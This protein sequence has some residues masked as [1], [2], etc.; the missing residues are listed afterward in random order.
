MW[1]KKSI[2]YS[3]IIKSDG[4]FKSCF[5]P[6]THIM[7]CQLFVVFQL[8]SHVQLFAT[9]WTV[10]C[11]ASL[12]SW[13]LYPNKE[14]KGRRVNLGHCQCIMRSVWWLKA[15]VNLPLIFLMVKA[16]RKTWSNQDSK[17][18]WKKHLSGATE[19]QSFQE[20]R[21]VKTRNWDQE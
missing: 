17:L 8:L 19:E 3:Q 4:N 12:S 10:A 7:L 6:E 5:T 13:Q 15:V 2:L 1:K 21:L 18:L 16:K 14:K 9:P 11:Q 20:L